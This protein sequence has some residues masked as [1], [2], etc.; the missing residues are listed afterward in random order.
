MAYIDRKKTIHQIR[1][2]ILDTKP[3][4]CRFCGSINPAYFKLYRYLLVQM[5]EKFTEN[6]SKHLKLICYYSQV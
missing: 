2:D 6:I 4:N 5:S 1:S 3:M